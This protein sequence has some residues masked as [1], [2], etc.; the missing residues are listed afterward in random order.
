MPLHCFFNVSAFIVFAVRAFA[1]V[2]LHV[3]CVVQEQGVEVEIQ[4][5]EKTW[6]E[7]G[8]PF[9]FSFS[10][11]SVDCHRFE[12]TVDS[13][14]ASFKLYYLL[15]HFLRRTVAACLKRFCAL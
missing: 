13:V 2:I 12:V 3:C 14:D 1:Q 8:N 9:P 11:C 6:V 5:S 4:G 10:V 15:F 7:G